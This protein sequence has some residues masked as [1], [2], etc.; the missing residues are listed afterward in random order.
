MALFAG[1][2]GIE[3]GEELT[4]DYNFNWFTGVSQ[5]TCHCGADNCR[6]ALGK[7]ADGFQ[8]ASP[9]VKGKDKDRKSVV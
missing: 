2:D 9:P 5:Q 3:A 1:D 8:R 6:G 7:K 4:Y